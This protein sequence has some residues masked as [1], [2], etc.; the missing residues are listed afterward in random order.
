[1]RA[2]ACVLAL[3]FASLLTHPAAAQVP[4]AGTDPDQVVRAAE[5]ILNDDASRPGDAALTCEQIGAQLQGMFAGMGDMQ[6]MLASAGRANAEVNATQAQLAERQ[7]TE[8]PALE[9]AAMAETKAAVKM[10]MNPV[11][12]LPE[13][14]AAKRRMDA[15]TAEQVTKGEEG[16][17]AGNQA[18]Q[19]YKESAATLVTRNTD[20]LTRMRVLTELAEQKGCA[21]PE[22]M[23]GMSEDGYFED[24]GE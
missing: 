7:V 20:D 1:M 24:E 12:A 3:A 8:G 5:K 2:V 16:G 17:R 22:G 4:G 9:A 23:P 13:A 6:A 18:L 15:L 10:S 11:A 14:I 19:E 21:P